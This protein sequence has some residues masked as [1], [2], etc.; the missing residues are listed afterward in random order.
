[1]RGRSRLRGR[2]QQRVKTGCV[3]WYAL[4]GNGLVGADLEVP[5]QARVQPLNGREVDGLVPEE[6][7]EAQLGEDADD[8]AGLADDQNPVDA[9]PKR[10]DG[11]VESRIGRQRHQFLFSRECLDL[12]QRDVLL[13]LGLFGDLVVQADMFLVRIREADHHQEVGVQVGVV[14]RGKGRLGRGGLA[15]EDDIGRVLLKE[16]LRCRSV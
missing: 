7:D 6:L 9:A 14:E 5:Q 15:H 11:L 8:V 1:M 2:G 16:Q 4:D 13:G 10:L 12:P 3:A